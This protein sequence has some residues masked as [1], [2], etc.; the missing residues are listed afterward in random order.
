MIFLGFG[1]Y[2][3]AGRQ[4]LEFEIYKRLSGITI[5]RENLI[6][7]YAIYSIIF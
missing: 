5:R 3:P 6:I 2:Q 7:N 1:I 4:S